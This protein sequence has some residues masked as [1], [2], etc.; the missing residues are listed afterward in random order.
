MSARGQSIEAI[1]TA[2]WC[3]GRITFD[4]RRWCC[5]DAELSWKAPQHLVVLTEE[6]GTAHTQVRIDGQMHFSGCD[7]P[8]ALSFVPALAERHNAYRGV[9]LAYSAL[10]IDPSLQEALTDRSDAADIV[11][12]INGGDDV[13]S[14][15]LTSLRSD[16][17]AG[18]IPA[19]AYIEHLVALILLRAANLPGR[20]AQGT[21]GPSPFSRKLL[22]QLDG[23]I[24]ANL[25][26]DISLSALA[27]QL[28][29]PIERFARRFKAT[30]GLAP[31]AYVINR[32]V[33][34]AEQLLRTTDSEIAAIALTLGFASQSHFTTTF[35][36][37]TGKTPTAYR[38]LC[39]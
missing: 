13:I 35:R 18:E 12:V 7:Q 8:G 3:D 29:M 30:T 16:L 37:V 19:T 11:P 25:G 4:H 22:A 23:Y 20:N 17:T 38:A 15:L 27:A 6:G 31:Y 21:S 14:G 5:A 9:D 26:C 39:L 24:E 28:D 32:R 10:W 2:S 36:R 1:H 33:R 34:R